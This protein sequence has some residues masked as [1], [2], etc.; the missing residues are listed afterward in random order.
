MPTYDYNDYNDDSNGEQESSR[1]F[2]WEITSW[3][4]VALTLLLNA[5]VILVLLIRQ[6]AYSVV[7]KGEPSFYYLPIFLGKILWMMS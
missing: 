4:L 5:I 1:R 7:N 3:I 6:N 2:G